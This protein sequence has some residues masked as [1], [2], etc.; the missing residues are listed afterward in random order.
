MGDALGLPGAT[1]AVLDAAEA[2]LVDHPESMARITPELAEAFDLEGSHGNPEGL[3]WALRRG[4]GAAAWLAPALRPLLADVGQAGSWLGLR[5]RTPEDLRPALARA[6][7]GVAADPG[8]PDEAFRWGVETLLLPLAPRPNEATW[9]G[10][11]LDRVGSD[12]KLIDKL[13][14]RGT[15][16]GVPAWI[17][18]A[19]TRG[20]LSN[21]QVARIDNCRRFLGSLRSRDA[22]S[23]MGSALPEVP[24]AERP[25]LLAQMLKSL[26]GEGLE[27]LPMVL[28]ACR[29][30]WPGAFDPGAKHL[31]TLA[32][33][34]ANRLAELRLTPPEWLGRLGPILERLG[35]GGGEHG[36]FEPDGLAAEIVAAASGVEADQPWPRRQLLLRDDRRWRALA[37]DARRDLAVEPERRGGRHPGPVGHPPEPG[38]AGSLLRP[39]AQRRRRRPPGR[40]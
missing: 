1:A 14:A 15:K 35:L 16:L 8:L 27:G 2:G 23:L 29:E 19:R 17:D 28:D 26:G 10:A 9:A 12:W 11:Y 37:V 4:K 3:A 32:W 25:A 40:P 6:F 13:S 39:D 38:E 36:G 20:E 24:P 31:K 30:A 7:L 21:E 18:G 33:P 34:L 5:D 22:S